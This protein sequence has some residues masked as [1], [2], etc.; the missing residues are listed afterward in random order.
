[1][2]P[3]GFEHTISGGERPKTY[4]LDRTATGIGEDN[5]L[6]KSKRTDG[7][8]AKCERQLQVD[9][10]NKLGIEKNVHEHFAERKVLTGASKT[11]FDN[12]R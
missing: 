3:V 5:T 2:P 9:E 10:K 6:G 11:N 7:G 4:A 1:M 8:A 12:E